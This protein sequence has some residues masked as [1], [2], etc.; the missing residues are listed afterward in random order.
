MSLFETQYLSY[1]YSIIMPCL[2]VD[3]LNS[4]LYGMAFMVVFF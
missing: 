1:L 4:F 2:Y 3:E